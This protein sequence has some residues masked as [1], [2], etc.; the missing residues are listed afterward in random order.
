MNIIS[1]RKIEVSE[2]P[3]EGIENIDVGD[4]LQFFVNSTGGTGY[5]AARALGM[6]LSSAYA[7]TA[8]AVRYGLLARSGAKYTITIRGLL[9]CLCNRCGYRHVVLERIR[10]VWESQ[11][12]MYEISAYVYILLKA[13]SYTGIGLRLAP[14]E[15]LCSS[16]TFVMGVLRKNTIKELGVVLS[17]DEGIVSAALPVLAEGLARLGLAYDLGTHFF[18]PGADL[19]VCKQPCGAQCR[20]NHELREFSRQFLLGVSL[21]KRLS[22]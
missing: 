9:Y 4:V 6:S 8:R 18:V 22:L 15:R 12:D 17:V 3:C 14:V 13:L 5:Q 20:L 7:K 16:A 10:G 2:Y 19:I 21:L 11:A 1:P